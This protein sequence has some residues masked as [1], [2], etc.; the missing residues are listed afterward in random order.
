MDSLYGR[1]VRL[2]A[3][4]PSDYDFLYSLSLGPGVG[5][6]WRH[7]GQS[8]SPERFVA[9]LWTDVTAQFMLT[10]RES[11]RQFGYVSCVQADHRHGFAFLAMVIS[12]EF[13]RRGW[14]IEG[15][16]LFVEYLF[17]TFGF[18]KL[19]LETF[20]FNLVA[21]ESATRG[22]LKEECRLS[23]YEAYQGGFADKVILSIDQRTWDERSVRVLGRARP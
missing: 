10:S 2:R 3:I 9:L 16:F 8:V 22:L 21:F 5:T 13:Q 19:Y 6:L 7:R 12:P 18:R 15:F 11:G 20:D 14:P 1:W 4:R 23:D 17:L